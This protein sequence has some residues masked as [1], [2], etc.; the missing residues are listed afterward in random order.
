MRK[1]SLLSE[2]PSYILN[3]A[4][5]EDLILVGCCAMSWGNSLGPYTL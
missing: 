1:R 4:V 2:Q 3:S 5:Y